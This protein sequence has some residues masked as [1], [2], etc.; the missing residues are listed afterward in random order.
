M[1]ETLQSILIDIQKYLVDEIITEEMYG[2]DS[3]KNRLRELLVI[4]VQSAIENLNSQMY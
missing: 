3:S 1:N 2:R 4:R